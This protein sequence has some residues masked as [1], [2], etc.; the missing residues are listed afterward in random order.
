MLSVSPPQE[1]CTHSAQVGMETQLDVECL[2][3]TRG[4]YSQ[5]SGRNGDTTGC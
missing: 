3:S 1:V 4:V 2:S 5:C